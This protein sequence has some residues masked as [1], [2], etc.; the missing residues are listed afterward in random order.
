MCLHFHSY[1]G[2]FWVSKMHIWGLYV[3]LVV[4]WKRKSQSQDSGVL[5]N[6]LK[7][8]KT[9]ET[10]HQGLRFILDYSWL[11]PAEAA[12]GHWSPKPIPP[13]LP[14]WRQMP[15]WT[16]EKVGDQLD[17]MDVCQV[18]PYQSSPHFPA[19]HSPPPASFL[20][21]R[22]KRKWKPKPAQPLGKT[23]SRDTSNTWYLWLCEGTPFF[24]VLSFLKQTKVESEKWTSDNHCQKERGE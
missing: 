1:P 11:M 15:D 4:A 13:Q 5:R 6:R 10:I 8:Q 22:D 14:S 9:R 16:Y 19:V 7:W 24:N 20:H 17:P 23:I 18:D 2:T 12:L 21:W 3:C